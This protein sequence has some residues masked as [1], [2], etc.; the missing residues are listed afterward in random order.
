MLAWMRNLI[1]R[2]S[3]RDENQRWWKARVAALEAVL[4][5]CDGTVFHVSANLHR[6]GFADVLRF[7]QY[8]P[9]ITYVTCGLI[10]NPRQIPNRWGQY[11][12][13][14]CTH[15]EDS[16][17]PGFLSRLAKYTHDAAIHP[18]DTMDIHEM[19]PPKS[20]VA[21]ILFARPDPPAHSF[22]VRGAPGGLMLCIGI[23]PSEFGA[24]K[25]YGSGVVTRALREKGIFPFTHMNR[26][27][28]A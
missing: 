23:T 24:C 4:G 28:I 9:G 8:V 6:H 22:S 19:R 18:G 15:D 17:A 2:S 10:G 14:V 26:E 13:V 3:D 11:D 20:D 7:R 1:A 16:W 27:S 5:P 25:T 12:L 21:A